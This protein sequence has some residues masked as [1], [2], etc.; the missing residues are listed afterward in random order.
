MEG[1]NSMLA[2]SENRRGANAKTPLST[3]PTENIPR[4]ELLVQQTPKVAPKTPSKTRHSKFDAEQLPTPPP[5]RRISP[6]SR[7]VSAQTL[8]LIA[9]EDILLASPSKRKRNSVEIWEDTRNA[10]RTTEAISQEIEHH[11]FPRRMKIMVSAPAAMGSPS[12]GKKKKL[13]AA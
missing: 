13:T 1:K 7:E 12:Q 2:S 11:V 3:V 9:D 6:S 10:D 8:Q 4:T 5:S